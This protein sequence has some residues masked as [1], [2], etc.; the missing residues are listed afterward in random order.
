[1]MVTVPN[2]FTRVKLKYCSSATKFLEVVLVIRSQ[3]CW[4]DFIDKLF[5]NFLIVVH[6]RILIA[7]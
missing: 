5:F 3:K 6:E 4:N 7:R 1:M 2:Q